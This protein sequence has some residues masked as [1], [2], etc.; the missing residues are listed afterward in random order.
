MS[1]EADK[2]CRKAAMTMKRNQIRMKAATFAVIVG[3]MTALLLAATLTAVEAKPLEHIRYH[4]SGS[5]IVDDYC[6]D[7]NVRI[8]FQDSGVLQIRQTGPNRLPKHTVSHHGDA[9][10]T[11]LATGKSFVIGWHY[12]EQEAKVTQ[13][14]DGTYTVLYQVPG[15]ETIYGP[16]GQRL[17]TS[18]GMYRLEFTVD[19]AGTPDDLSDDVVIGEEFVGDFGGQPQQPF[20]YCEQFRTLTA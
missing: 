18:G 20:D 3:G 4:D 10:F 2:D 7:M 9:T 5:E 8:D 1:T 6:G 13:N 19:N 17:N 11:N 16:D 15:P 14:G 12:L